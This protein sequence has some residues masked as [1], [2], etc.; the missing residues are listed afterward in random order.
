MVCREQQLEESDN[1]VVQL[2]FEDLLS[3]SSKSRESV[4]DALEKVLPCACE[5]E[6]TVVACVDGGPPFTYTG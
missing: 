3:T 4:L 5:H 6:E 1:Q 2:H